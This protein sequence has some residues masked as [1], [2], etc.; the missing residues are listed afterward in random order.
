MGHWNL[1][2]IQDDRDP[3]NKYCFVAEVYYDDDG[4]F[5]GYTFEKGV[6]LLSEDR[7]ELEKYY[8]MIADAFA[9]PSIPIE[10]FHEK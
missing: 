9:H 1:R 8:K 3:K 7:E 2:V 6:T 10:R 5:N 4:K